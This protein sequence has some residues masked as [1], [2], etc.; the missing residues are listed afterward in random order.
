L[1]GSAL[2]IEGNRTGAL[3]EERTTGAPDEEEAMD[4]LVDEIG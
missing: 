2:L 3:A 1:T 4:M